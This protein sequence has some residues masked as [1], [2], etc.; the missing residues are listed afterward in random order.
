VFANS[1]T[2][3]RAAA[4]ALD[5]VVGRRPDP[6]SL[7]AAERKLHGNILNNIGVGI[8][9]Q[10]R[11]REALLAL[12]AARE[13][14]LNDTLLQNVIFVNFNAGN[15]AVVLDEVGRYPGGPAAYPK[16]YLVRAVSEQAL[17]NTTAAIADFR[18][19]FA[20]GLRDDDS[21]GRYVGLLLDEGQVEA[22]AAF[23]DEYAAEQSS[24]DVLALQAL[25]SVRLEDEAR[26][27]RAL[28]ALEDPEQSSVEAALVAAIIHRQVGGVGG[29]AEFVERL[30]AELVS[31]ELYALLAATQMQAELFGAARRSVARGL[32]LAPTNSDLKALE[33]SLREVRDGEITL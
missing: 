22:S 29:L 16:L 27:Q 2:A 14:N 3:A 30:P 24:P 15:F 31:A 11:F 1:P 12:E 19:G 17:G 23:L 13:F 10:G 9:G 8:A 26:L 33:E 28:A 7:G 21:A 32:E 4:L 20:T 25:V 18:A 6:R 5:L